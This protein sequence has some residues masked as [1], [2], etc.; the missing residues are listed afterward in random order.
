MGVLP[1][2]P[3]TIFPTTTIGMSKVSIFGLDSRNFLY[4]LDDTADVI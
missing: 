3:A 2:P 1:V 4:L